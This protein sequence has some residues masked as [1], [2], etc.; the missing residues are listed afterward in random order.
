M[1][2]V[3]IWNIMKMSCIKSLKITGKNAIKNIIFLKKTNSIALISKKINV[4]KLINKLEQK[5]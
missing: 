5:C 2:N 4:Y 1:V 3:K